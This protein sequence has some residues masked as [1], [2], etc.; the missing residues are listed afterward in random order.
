MKI[1]ASFNRVNAVAEKEWLQIRRDSRS[2]I[3]AVAAPVI[4]IILF[5]YALS[6]DVK[7]VRM[8]V[9]DQDRSTLSRQ[10]IEKFSHTE[11]IDV[12][13]YIDDY[14]TSDRLIDRGDAAM[15]LILGSGFGKSFKSGKPVDVQL[16]IDGSDSTSATVALGYVKA[17]VSEY[18]LDVKIQELKRIGI[19]SFQTPVDIQNRVWY[20]PELV[21]KNFIIPGL[22]VIILAIISALIASLTVSREWERGTMET[23]VTTPLRSWEVVV[24][25]LIP[26]LFIGMFDVVLTVCVGY[27]VF[28]VPLRGSFIEFYLLALLFLAGT[29]TFG[30]FISSATKVQVLSVQVSMVA[31]Y[32]PSFI[33]SGFIFPIANMPVVLQG[34]TYIFPARYLII[35]VKGIALKGISATLLHTQI[36][37]L[38]CFFFITLALSIKNLKL[39]LQD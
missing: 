9:F 3:L 17:I 5:G 13:E 37:F 31:T 10:F 35:I 15:V 11:Y 28:G 34:I 7:H 21:S 12:T 36:I 24:G 27:F 33:L 14:K 6:V 38:A 23:L 1:I 22:I 8:A 19:S 16:L 2:L 29:S 39:R 18:N 25:K 30:I 4:L 20:N 26:Y 32:L